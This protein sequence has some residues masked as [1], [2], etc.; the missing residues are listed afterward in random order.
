MHQVLNI[1]HVTLFNAGPP[2]AIPTYNTVL[3]YCVIIRKIIIL[4][5]NR[6]LFAVEG[7]FELIKLLH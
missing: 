2:M 7:E 1:V 6:I 5:L 3:P 4:V